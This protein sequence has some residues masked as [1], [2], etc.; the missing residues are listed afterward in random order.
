MA[1]AEPATP[2]VTLEESI[3]TWTAL[4]NDASAAGHPLHGTA[5]IIIIDD[6]SGLGNDLAALWGTDRCRLTALSQ[7]LPVQ[8]CAA[9][10][11]LVD[12][13]PSD[14]SELAPYLRLLQH[15]GPALQATPDAHVVAVTRRDAQH[16]L[17]KT[18]ASVAAAGNK[19]R[20]TDSSKPP[21][22]NG[23]RSPALTLIAAT[24][25]PVAMTR[26]PSIA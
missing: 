4:S 7:A 15:Y 21:R 13:G 14:A 20:S 8:E 1:V 12:T 9:L 19:P 11:F 24:A 6:E 23:H 16:G 5:P 3:P 10:V 17:A 22:M 26:K 25:A 18:T 2:T